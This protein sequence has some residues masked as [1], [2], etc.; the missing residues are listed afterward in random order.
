MNTRGER[1][2]IAVLTYQRAEQLA[3]LLTELTAQAEAHVPPVQVMVV[4]ND[5]QGSASLVVESFAGSGVGYLHEPRPGIAA[6]R[7]A[8][9][10]AGADFDALIFIDDDERPTQFWLAAMID[11]YRSSACAAVVGPV[12]SEFDGEPDDFVG[13]GRFFARRRLP[14]G[15]E[16]DVA[17]TNNLLLDLHQVRAWGLGFDEA[18][19]LSGG[20]DTLFTAQ[21]V[22]RGGVMIWCDEALV[23]DRVP[24]DRLRKRWVLRRA[25]RSGNSRSRVDVKIASSAAQRLLIRLQRTAT[26]AV[27]CAG[28]GAH[29]AIGILTRSMPRRARGLRTM[30]RG[31]GMSSGAW[32]YVYHE[33]RRPP[34]TPVATVHSRTSA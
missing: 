34:P 15:T 30:A 27:R 23:V 25:F 12:V 21:V 19:G 32:G 16:V 31:L 9:L 3:G 10:A 28:G 13:A 7:N 24:A 8:A 14:T 20:S 29:L 17:A 33:Y 22:Q 4:D 18:F 6:A 1:I 11:T 5:P 26:G 2:L